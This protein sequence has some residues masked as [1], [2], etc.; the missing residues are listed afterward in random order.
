MSQTWIGKARSLSLWAH[1]NNYVDAYTT[2][3]QTP[4]GEP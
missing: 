1:I 4:P 2:I 3:H